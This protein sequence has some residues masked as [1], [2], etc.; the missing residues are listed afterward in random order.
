MLNTTL[1]QDGLTVGD[2]KFCDGGCKAI[3]DSGTSLLAGPKEAVKQINKAIGATGVI[4]AEC[5]QY[6]QVVE[7]Y[8]L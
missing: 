8:G 1:S 6:I 2:S 3:A 4:T 7:S 5:D